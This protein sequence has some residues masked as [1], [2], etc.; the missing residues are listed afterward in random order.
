MA[1]KIKPK[2][3]YSKLTCFW[4]S[5]IPPEK[6]KKII[7]LY[8]FIIETINSERSNQSWETQTA[9]IPFLKKPAE[10]RSLILSR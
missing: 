3:G 2:E 9:L 10:F 5:S 8:K 7:R 6:F 1:L 4:I